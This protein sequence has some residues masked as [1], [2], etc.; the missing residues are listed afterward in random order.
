M[1]KMAKNNVD[2]STPRG[3]GDWE[4]LDTAGDVKRFLRFLILEVKRGRVSIKKANCMGQLANNILHA[5]E[6]ADIETRIAALESEEAA[7]T[8]C[9]SDGTIKISVSR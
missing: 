3:A 2:M 7:G 5:I 4:A 6:V 1:A 9:P 8:S